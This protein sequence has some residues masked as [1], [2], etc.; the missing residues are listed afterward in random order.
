ML[1]FLVCL[2]LACIYAFFETENK[3][4]GH[5]AKFV[6]LSV[7]PCF[8]SVIVERYIYDNN[9]QEKILWVDLLVVISLLIVYITTV[10]TFILA[11][12]KGYTNTKIVE[13]NKAL[14]IVCAIAFGAVIIWLGVK[15]F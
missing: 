10:I 9:G 2:S 14:L 7:L 11:H 8:F 4:P 12:K 5:P 6:F 13:Q 3:K 15:S 1:I